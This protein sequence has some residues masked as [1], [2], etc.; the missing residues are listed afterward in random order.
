MLVAN[1]DTRVRI[2]QWESTV[3][4]ADAVTEGRKRKKGWAFGERE[5]LG[6]QRPF[7]P[8]AF[9]LFVRRHFGNVLKNLLAIFSNFQRVGTCFFW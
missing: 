1:R 8:M 4:G 2:D 7:P 3:G 9:S 5:S 6:R